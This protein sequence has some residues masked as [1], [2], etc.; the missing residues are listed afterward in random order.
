VNSCE[1]DF[2]ICIWYRG[3][4]AIIG[5]IEVSASVGDLIA[6]GGKSATAAFEYQ[7]CS[8]AQGFSGDEGGGPFPGTVMETKGQK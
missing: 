6:A 3:Y 1:Q 2:A 4:R 7:P 5:D 8:E